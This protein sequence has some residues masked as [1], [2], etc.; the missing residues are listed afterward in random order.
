MATKHISQLPTI[1]NFAGKILIYFLS[2]AWRRL[3]VNGPTDGEQQMG[4]WSRL[5]NPQKLELTAQFK[6][7]PWCLILHTEVPGF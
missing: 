6:P 7:R 3:V 5:L 4:S 2:P 1:L